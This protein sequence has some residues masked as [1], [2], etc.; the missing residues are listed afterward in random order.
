MFGKPK[1]ETAH[2]TD[3]ALRTN[4]FGL[5]TVYSTDFALRTNDFGLL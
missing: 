3:L 4:D 1:N 2:S 5:V